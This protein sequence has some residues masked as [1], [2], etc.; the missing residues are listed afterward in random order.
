MM[1]NFHFDLQQNNY[2]KILFKD[3]FPTTIISVGNNLFNHNRIWTNLFLGYK[4]YNDQM[5]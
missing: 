3:L 4:L 5:P 2:F 1:I